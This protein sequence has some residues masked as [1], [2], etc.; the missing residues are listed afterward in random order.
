LNDYASD[1]SLRFRRQFLNSLSPERR[2]QYLLATERGLRMSVLD[3]QRFA[4]QVKKHV[5]EHEKLSGGAMLEA[6]HTLPEPT[7]TFDEWFWARCRRLGI[8]AASRVKFAE[9]KRSRDPNEPALMAERLRRDDALTSL[10]VRDHLKQYAEAIGRGGMEPL[11]PYPPGTFDDWF[12]E[13]CRRLG[14][15]DEFRAKFEEWKRSR[16]T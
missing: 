14:L 5:P 4:D 7:E 10:R 12:W 3:G 1:E 2:K 16:Q 8:E 15:E 9:W 13:R 11:S 6:L